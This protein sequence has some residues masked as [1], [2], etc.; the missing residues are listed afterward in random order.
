[1]E[2]SV[3]TIVLELRSA[4]D[5]PTG[6]SKCRTLQIAK[7]LAELASIASANLDISFYPCSIVK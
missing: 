3:E 5:Q 4:T 2:Y 6:N 1:M 7:I